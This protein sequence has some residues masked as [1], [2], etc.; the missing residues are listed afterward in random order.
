[1]VLTLCLSSPPQLVRLP[2]LL[3]MSTARKVELVADFMGF[4]IVGFTAALMVR[5]LLHSG[6]ISFIPPASGPVTAA[7]YMETL[8]S[9]EAAWNAANP[10]NI[11]ATK[12]PVLPRQTSLIT[13]PS[14]SLRKEG[15]QS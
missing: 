6:L 11:A 7:E 15:S 9:M 3:V 14:S 8:R 12:P 10:A 2:A 5:R 13:R 4:F 1:M